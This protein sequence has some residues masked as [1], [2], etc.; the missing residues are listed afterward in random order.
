M[1]TAVGTATTQALP[2]PLAELVTASSKCMSATAISDLSTPRIVF[3]RVALLADTAT[4]LRPH[5]GMSTASQ[6]AAAVVALA[7]VLVEKKFAVEKALAAWQEVVHPQ[8]QAL[9]RQSSLA[10]DRLQGFEQ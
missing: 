3:G 6:A 10:G 1:A 2:E 5:S 8:Q 4:L 7:D 9:S